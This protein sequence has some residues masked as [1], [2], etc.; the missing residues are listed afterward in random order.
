MVD[1]AIIAINGGVVQRFLKC[2]PAYI[3]FESV[4]CIFLLNAE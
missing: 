3:L 1:A 4:R 2:K